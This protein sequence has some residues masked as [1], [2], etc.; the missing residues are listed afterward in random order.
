VARQELVDGYSSD[1]LLGLAD[2][3]ALEQDVREESRAV[4]IRQRERP[5]GRRLDDRE[6]FFREE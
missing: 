5:E 3:V 4:G 2:L 6:S 1:D